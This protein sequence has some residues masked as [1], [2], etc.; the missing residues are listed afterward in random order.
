MHLVS[1]S[2]LQ[3]LQSKILL[4]PKLMINQRKA[5]VK[6]IENIEIVL[7]YTDFISGIQTTKTLTDC[8]FSDESETILPI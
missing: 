3:G 7:Q 8:S 4:R 1:E 6:H 2:V 5:S